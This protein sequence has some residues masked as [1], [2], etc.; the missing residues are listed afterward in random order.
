MTRPAVPDNL[1]AGEITLDRDGP[2]AVFHRL[3]RIIADQLKAPVCCP[4][5]TAG[6]SIR[7]EFTFRPLLQELSPPVHGDDAYRCAAG[8]APLVVRQLARLGLDIKLRGGWFASLGETD[9]T[10]LRRGPVDHGFLDAI[11]RH[12]HLLVRHGAGV[13]VELIAVMLA[14]SWPTLRLVVAVTRVAEARCLAT[15]LRTAGVDAALATHRHVPRDD[16]RVVVATLG[17]LGRTAVGLHELDILLL[18]DAAEAIAT[19]GRSYLCPDY[20]PGSIRVPRVVGMVPAGRRLA[21]SDRIGL[22]EMCGPNVYE[23]PAL[24]VTERPVTYAVVPIYGGDRKV[25]ALRLV[26]RSLR[27]SGR[28]VDRGNS[29]VSAHRLSDQLRS[30]VWRQPIR[31]RRLAR[32]ARL[33]VAGDRSALADFAEVSAVAALP[34]PASVMIITGNLEHARALAHHLPGWEVVDP[35]VTTAGVDINSDSPKR[36]I[37]TLDGLRDASLADID[38]IIRADAG[39]G[40]IPLSPWALSA[41]SDGPIRPLVVVDAD[42]QHDSDLQRRSRLRQAAYAE[43]GWLRVGQDEVDLALDYILEQ[44][45]A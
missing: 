5:V 37:V 25:S 23:L 36:Q 40:A 16:A 12:S 29:K 7:P 22:I 24:G 11:G 15:A 45:R 1:E 19:V 43:Q 35:A 9:Q 21:P 2:H 17:Q 20:W 31:N 33:L 6:G 28:P 42:D 18:G 41:L 8:L 13:R 3:P 26:G 39:N 4:V 32:L 14:L 44:R 30:L 27:C 10:S 34:V 38:V